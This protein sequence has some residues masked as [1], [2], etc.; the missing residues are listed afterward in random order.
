MAISTLRKLEELGIRFCLCG[1]YGMRFIRQPNDIDISIHPEDYDKLK[2]LFPGKE[3]KAH[4]DTRKYTI[5]FSI[6][7][8]PDSYP[9]GFSYPEVEK[10][11]VYDSH[12]FKTW[13]IHTV[14][15]WKVA[16]GRDKD[17]ED[18]KSIDDFLDC[19]ATE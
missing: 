13:S 7:C 12:M 18:I 2:E 15:D 5:A 8:F 11:L 10:D 16:F 3:E 6:E 4:G 14:R 19:I 17:L 9:L 1:S